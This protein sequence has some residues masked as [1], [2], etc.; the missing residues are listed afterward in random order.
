MKKLLCLLC[1][2]L[3]LVACDKQNDNPQNKPV[4]KI[5]VVDS[6]SGR[7]AEN[8]Q[9]VRTAIELA[10]ENFASSDIDFDFIFEDYG[11]ESKRASTAV[12]KLI[13]VDKVD[14]LI[15]WSSVAGNV[16]SPLAQHHKIPHMAIC[17]DENV[18][19]GKYNFTH[20]TP[21]EPLAEKLVQNIEKLHAKN[22]ALFAV[23]QPALQKHT[24]AVEKILK[25]KN[26]KF[27]RFNFSADNIDFNMMVDSAK[28]KKFDAWYI[29]A[30]PPSLD[31]FLKTYFQ[32]EVK[33]PL[34]AIDSLLF[35]NDKKMV[36]GMSFVTTPDGDEKLLKKLTNKNGSTNYFSV[37][38]AFDVANLLMTAYN[39]LY[40][41]NGEVPSSDMVADYLLNVKDY[42]GA[43][44]KL[45]IQSNGIIK[46]PAVVKQI[47]NGKAVVVKE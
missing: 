26:I 11:Y 3:S 6:L 34:V 7:Y 41:K 19:H 23:Y 29:A 35:A 24:D 27:E 5:G 20:F 32:K 8:G 30:L 40:K 36:E 21:S 22:V 13:N 37:G 28:N 39:D 45:E 2:V 25:T 18:A 43:V 14:A 46:S 12:N 1:M 15:S 31:S 47:K 9:N 38:Y 44:G 10:K 33:S 4:V 17:N 16:V 42:T